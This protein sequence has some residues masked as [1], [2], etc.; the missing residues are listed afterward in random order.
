[1]AIDLESGKSI[2]DYLGRHPA[3]YR[4]IRWS[5]CFGRESGLQ[6]RAFAALTLKTGDTV[7]DLGC[8]A[9]ANFALLEEKVGASGNIIALDYSEGMLTQARILATRRGWRNIEFIQGDAARMNLPGDSLDGA[10]CTFALSAMPHEEAALRCVAAALK[11]G[12]PFV[13]FDAKTFTGVAKIINPL[14]GPFFKHTTNWDYEKD[15]VGKIGKVFD[16]AEVHEFNSG[17]NY[18]AV[19]TRNN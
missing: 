6:R 3:L 18:I 13:V 15:V 11:L 9:G 10:V 14:V 8:G 19:A 16:L 1:M 2:Y 12:A 5:V 17:C 7:L 4:F